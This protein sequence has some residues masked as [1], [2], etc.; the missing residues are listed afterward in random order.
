MNLK[1]NSSFKDTKK[2]YIILDGLRGVVEKRSK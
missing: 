1:F 2:H